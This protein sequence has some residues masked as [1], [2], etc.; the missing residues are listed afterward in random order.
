MRPADSARLDSPVWRFADAEAGHGIIDL[1]GSRAKA[2]R[3]LLTAWP[4]ASPHA[5]GKAKFGIVGEPDRFGFGIEGHD[6]Q[7]WSKRFFAHDSHLMRHIRKHRWRIEIWAEVL[8]THPA[9]QN[10]S[11]TCDCIFH[12]RVHSA[13]LAL[14]NHRANVGLG[15][16][17]VA[18]TEFFYLLHASIYECPV[19]LAVNIA[20]L[21]RQA[22]LPCIHKRTP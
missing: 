6:S 11:A 15:I 12:M 3:D 21:N 20:A 10:A 1:H 2:P 17:S 18:H 16:H 19:N 8:Q 5:R 9:N 7:N 13:K 4:I 22:G 14:V